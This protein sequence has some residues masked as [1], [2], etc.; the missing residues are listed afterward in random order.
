MAPPTITETPANDAY[1]TDVTYTM[2][3]KPEINLNR[4]S[5]IGDLFLHFTQPYRTR[6]AVHRSSL[7]PRLAVCFLLVQA[8]VYC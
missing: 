6:R 1:V 5:F 8:V 3:Y 4:S 2:N 7:R